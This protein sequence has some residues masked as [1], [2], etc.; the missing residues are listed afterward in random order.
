M[1]SWAT[2]PPDD[3]VFHHVY[4]IGHIHSKAL[5]TIKQRRQKSSQADFFVKR[6]LDDHLKLYRTG[7]KNNAN[8]GGGCLQVIK[9]C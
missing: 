3:D 4:I 7:L 9:L 6:Q 2:I 1:G 8:F 5:V